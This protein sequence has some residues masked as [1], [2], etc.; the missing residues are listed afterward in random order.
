MLKFFKSSLLRLSLRLSLLVGLTSVAWAADPGVARS[1]QQLGETNPGSVLIYNY[2]TSSAISPNHDTVIYLTNTNSSQ[3]VFVHLFF[4]SGADC[5]MAEFYLCLTPNQTGRFQTS[6]MDPGTSGYILAVATDANGCPIKFNHLLG[7]AYVKTASG[8]QAKLPA[9][10][11]A[12]IQL[13]RCLKL[14]SEATLQFDG[15]AYGRLPRTLALDQ[16]ASVMDGNNTFLVINSLGGNLVTNSIPSLDLLGLLY[17]DAKSVVSFRLPAGGCQLSG[18]LSD[19]FPQIPLGFSN[20]IPAGHS[21]WLR[22][23]H[24][25][26]PLA[27]SGAAINSTTSVWVLNGANGGANLNPL[28]YNETTTITIPVQP[29]TC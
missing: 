29:P 21:G 2:Y 23:Y 1:A 15:L 20:F 9:L 11:V 13:N 24:F 18:N 12:A 6:A 22:L 8:H 4:I 5:E 17:N 14:L 7:S 19:N 27:I 16:I 26:A 28:S 25:T 3:S 10:A